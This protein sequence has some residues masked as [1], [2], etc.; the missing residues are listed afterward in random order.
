MAQ[1]CYCCCC[2]ALKR[3]V[4]STWYKKRVSKPLCSNSSPHLSIRRMD[5][6]CYSRLRMCGSG[7]DGGRL[8]DTHEEWGPGSEEELDC[9]IPYTLY[10]PRLG[11][12][13]KPGRGSL[14]N[15]G[16]HRSRGQA[17]V[18]EVLGGGRLPPRISPSLCQ[19]KKT[20]FLGRMVLDDDSPLTDTR[21]PR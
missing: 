6:M 21:R 18:S 14:A 19:Y 13:D 16:S 4:A 15:D 3:S 17:Q 1:S 11:L 20:A 8:Y 12:L 10:P 9:P 5:T 7:G 2:E